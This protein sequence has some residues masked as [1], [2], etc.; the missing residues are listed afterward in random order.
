[1]NIFESI[2][3][4]FNNAKIKYLVAGGVA[5][6]LHGFV[7][8]TG[9][10]D[11]LVLLE[12]KNLERLDQLMKKIGYIERIPVSVP[13]LKDNKKVKKWLKEK[14][15]KAYSFIPPKNS[16][17]QIDIIIE[18]SLKFSQFD[19]KKIVKKIDNVNIS[20]ICLDDLIKM[21]KKANRDQ[22]IFDLKSLIELKNL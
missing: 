21:K 1:M 4:H 13:E 2:F 20:V 16:L 6:N 7:R 10:L 8:F 17:L 19:R 9:D 11:I 12:E 5:V 14:N 3:R 22:D 18:E 15:L